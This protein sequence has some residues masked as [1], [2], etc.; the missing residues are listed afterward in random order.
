MAT[1]EP[2][3]PSQAQRTNP[4]A[5]A[6]LVCGIIQFAGVFPAGIVAIILG[7]LAHRQIRRT[8]EKGSGMA[9]AGL[10]LG[11]FSLAITLLATM[12]IFL[13]SGPAPAGH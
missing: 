5:V 10:V 12:V 7:H 8:G 11:Y 13:G 3:P 9:T 4:L 2:V 6:A 1:R